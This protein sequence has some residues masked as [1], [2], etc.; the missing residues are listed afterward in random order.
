MQ[1]TRYRFWANIILSLSVITAANAQEFGGLPYGIDWKQLR[2]SSANIIFPVDME[3]EARRI[4]SIINSLADG[5]DFDLGKTKPI[6]IVLQNQ[7]IVSNGFVGLAPWRSYYYISPLQNPFSLGSGNWLD[8]LTVHEFRHVEQLSAFNQGITKAVT[9]VF[10]QAAWSG[11]LSLVVPDWYIEGDAVVKETEFSTMGRGKIPAF[12]AGMRALAYDNEKPNYQMIRN[13]SLRKFTPD[14][15]RLGYMMIQYAKHEFGENVWSGIMGQSG[16]FKGLFY[17]FSSAIRSKTGLNTKGLFDESFDQLKNNLSTSSIE[18]PVLFEPDNRTFTDLSYPHFYQDGLV[19]QRTSFNHIPTFYYWDGEKE[20]RLV[21]RGTALNSYFDCKQDYLA[22]TQYSTDQLR[23]NKDFNDITLYHIPSKQLRK[24]T[25]Q[26]KYYSPDLHPT[27]ELIAAVSLTARGKSELHILNFEGALVQQ[28]V[29]PEEF[30]VFPTWSADGESIFFTAR[31]NDGTSAI[32]QIFE[33][34]ETRVLTT[35][36]NSNIGKIEV[37]SNKLYFTTSDLPVENI[38]ELDLSSQVVKKVTESRNGAFQPQ[39]NGDKLIYQTFTSMGGRFL[40]VELDENNSR[41]FSALNTVPIGKH[42]ITKG[43]L[44]E[45]TIEPVDYYRGLN[46][47]NPH[48]IYLDYDSDEIVSLELQSEDILNNLNINTGVRY[49]VNAELYQPYFELDYGLWV[50]HINLSYQTNKNSFLDDEGNLLNWREHLFSVGPYVDIRLNRGKLNHLVRNKISYDQRLLRGDIRL[51]LPSFTYNLFMIGAQQQARQHILPRLGYS[52]R[53]GYRQSV[54]DFKANQFNIATAMALPGVLPTHSL[55]LH[56]DYITNV[57]QA[58][59]QF[60]NALRVPRGYEGSLSFLDGYR[61]SA[62]YHFPVVYP[63]F[64]IAGMIYFQRLRL[65]LF[66]DWSEL[67][68]TN[69]N[70]KPLS[71]GIELVT[72]AKIFNTEPVTFGIRL[73][74]SEFTDSFI[75]EFVTPLYRF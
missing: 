29:F 69:G 35:P 52:V 34:G 25:K 12:M 31:Y 27:E 55:I 45:T 6:N 38:Y 28:Y 37:G 54:N 51:E 40:S 70:I 39:V 53:L 63:D 19:Y 30:V 17:P 72:D 75:S 57:S 4:E 56:A 49:F 42:S 8:I 48:S 13:G 47:L 5:K 73:T 3:P 11:L 44:E 15:Y 50:P 26:Q 24:V 46:L 71:T 65:N 16:R 61:L 64:G 14:H 33:N 7:T 74:Y 22:F 58:D 9:S 1:F 10:G 67:K 66:L 23:V 68:F 60:P 59:Y 41:S 36:S 21:V 18:A 32:L 20:H 62:N 43:N 2:L